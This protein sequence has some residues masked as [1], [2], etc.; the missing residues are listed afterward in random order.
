MIFNEKTKRKK[1]KKTAQISA[2]LPVT[3]DNFHDE[4]ISVSYMRYNYSN[5]FL[6]NIILLKS[7]TL[8]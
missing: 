1:E 5:K 4:I 8:M 7:N 6:Y 3:F 2:L